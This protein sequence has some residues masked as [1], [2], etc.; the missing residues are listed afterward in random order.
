MTKTTIWEGIRKRA[1]DI[2]KSLKSLGEISDS[3]KDRIFRERAEKLSQIDKTSEIDEKLINI[4]SFNI[5]GELYGIDVNYLQDAYEIDNITKIPCTSSFLSGL[6]NYKGSILTIINL[7][8][9][10]NLSDVKDSKQKEDKTYKKH[11][12]PVMNKILILN[13]AGIKAGIVVDYFGSMLKLFKDHIKPVSPI[14]LDKNKIIKSEAVI[15]NTSLQII[16]PE[17]LLNDERLI[18]NEV[19]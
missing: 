4:I 14:F 8:A 15:N 2:Q 1:E 11:K 17:A 13:Y 9:L 7:K 3:E 10:L 12:T 5:S 18:V 16:D 6:I 19:I